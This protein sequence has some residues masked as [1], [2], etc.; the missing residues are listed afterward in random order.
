MGADEAILHKLGER[1]KELTALHRTARILQDRERP[2]TA[3]LGEV[4]GVLPAAWQY[5]EVAVARIRF[6]GRDYQTPGFEETEWVQEVSFTTRSGEGGS[7]GV[8]Y[9]EFRPPADEGPF[10]TEERELIESLAEMLRAHLDQ[11]R[12]WEALSAARDDLEAQV[13]ARTSDLRRLASRLTLAEERERR[14]IAAD[15][16]DHIGQGLAFIKTRIRELQSNAVFGG[17]ETTIEETLRLLDQTIRYTRDLTG[18]ISPPV[19]YELGLEPAL[20]W[21]AEHFTSRRGLA[22]RFTRTGAVRPVPEEIAVM[23]F[24]S[25]R[26]LLLNALAHSGVRES[27]LELAWERPLLR[28]TVTDAGRGFD[29]DRAPAPDHDGF[30]LFSIRERCGDLGGRFEVVSAPGKG[31]RAMLTVPLPQPE[32]PKP[33]PRSG[34]V[35]LPE[36]PDVRT[37]GASSTAPR[38]GRRTGRS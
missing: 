4:V 6:R 7:I 2:V 13:L 30:G 11:V 24:K 35:D 32:L 33:D 5:P 15:L 21:L 3:L 19:L 37:S 17:F 22:V 29:P 8:G 28:V 23:L 10:L 14:R 27:H 1:V 20:D 9:L 12:A 36:R 26:E 34:S 16:H 38:P 31:C 18:E 25:A